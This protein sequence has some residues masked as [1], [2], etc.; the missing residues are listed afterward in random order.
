MIALPDGLGY[1][2]VV[3]EP[4]GGTPKAP[5][6]E[7]AAYFLESDAKTP[8]A[9]AP[10]AVSLEVILAEAKTR[11]AVPL[12]PSPKADTPSGNSRFAAV[13]PPGF[14]GVVTG[15]KLSATLGGREVV[16]PF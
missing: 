14:D 16:I 6:T 12:K 13:P 10:T 2:E 4:A 1:A 8:M 9:T 11:Q 15:G 5:Q 3:A 7:L